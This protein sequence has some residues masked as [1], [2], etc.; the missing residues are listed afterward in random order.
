MDSRIKSRPIFSWFIPTRLSYSTKSNPR[1]KGGRFEDTKDIK[2]NITKELFTLHANEFKKC[3]Q[4]FYE[5]AKKWMT[6]E[7]EYFEEY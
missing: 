1:W 4:Q 6:T 5:L 7:G 2:I 3:L